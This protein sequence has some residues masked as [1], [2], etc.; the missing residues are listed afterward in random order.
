MSEYAKFTIKINDTEMQDDIK[1]DVLEIVVDNNLHLPDMVTI[2]LYD[3]ELT[4]VDETKFDL[5][6]SIEVLYDTKV[7]FK[8]EITSLEPDFSQDG[9]VTFVLR[10]YDL[11]HRLHRG[12]KTIAHMNTDDAALVKAIAGDTSVG[13]TITSDAAAVSYEYILQHNQTDMEFLLSLAERAGY[14]LYTT[15]GK[16][17]FKKAG[18]NT[19][20]PDLEWGSTLISFQPR[21]AGTHQAESFE[22]YGWDN[23]TKAEI[24]ATATPDTSWKQASMSKTGGDLAK[25]GFKNEATG[26]IVSQPV[27]SV[28]AATAMAKSLSHEVGSRFIQAEGI[29]FGDPTLLAGT[30]VKISGVGTRFAGKYYVTAATHVYRE[31]RYEISFSVT[32]QEPNTIRNLLSDGD[33]R[34]PQGYVRGPMI[35]LV[36]NLNDD[37]DLGR[38]KVTFPSLGKSPDKKAIES[39][40]VR[41]A[42]PMA[43][44]ATGVMYMPELNDEI[45]VGFEQGDMNRPYMIGALWNSTDKPP[46]SIKKIFASNKVNLRVIQSRSG[47]KFVFDDTMGEEQIY[48]YD[49]TG[50]NKIT[51]FTKTNTME[52]EMQKDINITSKT[53]NITLAANAGDII[54]N[55]NNIKATTK[56]NFTVN[57]TSNIEMTATVNGNY[58][59]NSMS[60]ITG[61]SSLTL[62]NASAQVAISGP[63]VDINN[64]GLTVT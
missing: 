31:G 20:G 34:E 27:V 26:I 37:K 46:E 17:M 36:T 9:R 47:H 24:T 39:N 18:T 55:C 25:T 62:K 49:K 42:S 5:G 44:K 8:G 63:S 19:T 56:Q 33:S 43:G 7:L 38:F 14:Y 45:L 52:I 53:G 54:M 64:G 41:V 2:Q 30:M 23:V 13:L 10:G 61:A 50:K 48:I 51:I 6:K 32:G 1:D 12:R 29:C 28:D 58:T 59:A 15:Q 60:T 11:S 4:W 3:D 16:L 21:W 57:A 22:V 35:G 40:W